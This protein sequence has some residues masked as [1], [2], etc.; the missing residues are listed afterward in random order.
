VETDKQNRKIIVSIEFNSFKL[1]DK[2]LTKE[3]IRERLDICELYSIQCFKAQTNQDFIACFNY[4]PLSEE[5]MQNELKQRTNWPSNVYWGTRQMNETRMKQ[6]LGDSECLFLVRL[7]SDDMYE[8]HFIQRL[9]DIPI[10]PDT[11]AIICK[12]GYFHI[13]ETKQVGDFHYVSPPFYTLIYN[14]TDYFNMK[15][16]RLKGHGSL[17][18]ILKYECLEGK[19]FMIQLTGKNSYMVVDG[20]KKYKSFYP[21]EEVKKIFEQFGLNE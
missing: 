18:N 5:V 19:N 20:F 6:W 2:R 14:A 17:V 9:H 21:P 11:Q 8:K 13:T 15:R 7:D 12:D 3:W 16:Y 1:N 4:D 10:K